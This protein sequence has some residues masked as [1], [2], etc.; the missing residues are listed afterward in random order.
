MGVAVLLVLPPLV[1]QPLCP[2]AHLS[3]SNSPPP[4]LP[5]PLPT[6]RPSV[7]RQHV[8]GKY[9]EA[10]HGAQ[11]PTDLPRPLQVGQAVVARHPGNRQLH[12]GTILTVSGGR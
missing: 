7:G 12:D 1:R 3:H 6:L 9:E 2:S 4:P 10:A 8:R 11:L 5:P